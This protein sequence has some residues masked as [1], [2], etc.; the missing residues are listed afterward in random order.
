MDIPLSLQSFVAPLLQIIVINLV[1]SGDN[2]AVIAL[3]ARDLKPALQR[4]VVWWGSLVAVML[5]VALTFVATALLRWPYLQTGGG[6]LLL[7]VA[8]RLVQPPDAHE[9]KG[10]RCSPADGPMAAIRAI[11]VADL[12][13]S[14]DN[15]LSLA[16]VAEG[17]MVLLVI[18][19]LTS[20]PLVVWGSQFLIRL[21]ERFPVLILLASAL[22]GHVAGRMLF[23]DPAWG[24]VAWLQVP[25]MR[26]FLPLACAAFVVLFGLRSRL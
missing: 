13:M 16:A 19:L 22:L 26:V 24:D 6:V 1:L 2:A 25:W 11:L 23:M 18:G 8:W 15:V 7:W 12:V 9:R 3:A 14:L 21:M 10:E 4:R 20:V 17:H 5:R